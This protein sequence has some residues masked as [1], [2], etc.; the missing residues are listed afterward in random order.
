[1]GTVHTT[2]K[3]LQEKL[4]FNAATARIVKY[5]KHK[6]SNIKILYL[7]HA[8]SMIIKH[9]NSLVWRVILQCCI[10]C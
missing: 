10:N 7:A 8:D 2:L 6:V 3:C 4:V 5:Q 9:Y 1:M